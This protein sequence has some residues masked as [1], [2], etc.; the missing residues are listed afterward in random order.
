ML[1][2]LAYLALCACA[3]LY[4]APQIDNQRLQQLANDPFWISLGHYEARKLGGWRSYVSDDK[5]FLAADGAH[6]PDAELR[7]TVEALYAPVS[8]GDKHPQCVYPART[9]W[10]KAQL[11]LNDLPKVECAE[12]TQWFTDVAPH[13]TVMIFPAAYLNSPSS[14]F[15]HT[16][17][18]I[19]QADVQSNKTALLSYAI[20]FGAYIEGSDNSILYAWKGLAG[21]YPG[22]FALVPYQEK[23]SEYRS[24]ENRDLWEYRLNLTPEETQRMVEHVWELKQIQFDYFFFDENC[25]YR[26]LELLQVARPGLQLT[27]QFPLTAIPTDTVKAVK[28]AGLVE[29]IEYRP[30]REREL[31][32]R[33]K[34]LDPEEQQWVLQVSADQTQLQNPTF[35][36]LPKAR[37]AL[38]IDAAYRL[39]RYRANGLERDTGRSQRS[40]E[41]LRA[42]N[43]NPAPELQVER[44]ELPENGH[45]SRTWQLGAG[46]RDDKAFA[47]YGLRMAYH[48]LNDNAPGFPLGAQIEILQLKL[49]QYEGNK[50]QV[51][52]LDLANIRSLTPRNALLQPWSWQV[53]GGLERVLSKHG[54]ERLVTHVNG[55]AGGTWQLSD[56]LLGYALGTVRVE[57]NNDFAAFVS[58]AAGYNTGVLWRNPVGNLSLET[59]ADYFTNGEVRR[60]LS[61]NQQWEI[62]RNLGLRLTAQREFSHLA[63]PVNEVMLELKWYHY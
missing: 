24:L 34:V 61:L 25:S 15:G 45:E 44:P 17:L 10:L 32:D 11:N 50:W 4:A 40:Y 47:E 6:H 28:E 31:L 51:Q 41:L 22:L 54:N 42:I 16:L 36:A 53:G 60:S 13:S 52:Q 49:R 5:F 33:A 48:D 20:N 62:S 26:L 12:F 9:R 58:P 7:A 55:G 30:S 23:L 21:G 46:S 8:L 18:R 39:E 2:R 57:H 59:K 1:K 29:S 38:I 43:Q 14:M 63:S 3:P 35:M 19:D 27:T 56:N 37:Q